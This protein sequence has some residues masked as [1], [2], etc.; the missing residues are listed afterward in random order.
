[1]LYNTIVQ[2]SRQQ[3]RQQARQA[4]E[5]ASFGATQKNLYKVEVLQNEAVSCS[6]ILFI[7]VVHTCSWFH[8]THLTSQQQHQQH[9]FNNSKEPLRSVSC[10]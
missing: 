5:Q 7:D 8:V 10:K 6:Y 2:H 9:V 1:M 4:V 3:V